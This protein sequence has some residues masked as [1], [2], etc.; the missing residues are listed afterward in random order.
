M[1]Q[2]GKQVKGEGSSAVLHKFASPQYIYVAAYK[3]CRSRLKPEGFSQF[4]PYHVRIPHWKKKNR[5]K[6]SRFNA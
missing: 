5:Q 1:T 6:I 3:L 2:D 4:L